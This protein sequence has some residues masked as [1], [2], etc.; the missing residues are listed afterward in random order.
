M[1]FFNSRNFE[2][3]KRRNIKYFEFFEYRKKK[4]SVSIEEKSD[5]QKRK[6]RQ[7][8]KK[9]EKQRKNMTKTTKKRLLF[10]KIFIFLRRG[11][12]CQMGNDRNRQHSA[13]LRRGRSDLCN[14]WRRYKLQG[15]TKNNSN[16]YAKFDWLG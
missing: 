4:N 5:S 14:Q 7:E 3:L 11:G 15:I 1:V 10:I 16:C 2:Q 9:E 12:R 6:Q 8:T 13:D